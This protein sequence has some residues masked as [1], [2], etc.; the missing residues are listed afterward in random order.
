MLVDRYS[1]RLGTLDSVM[2]ITGSLTKVANGNAITMHSVSEVKQ[3]FKEKYGVTPTDEQCI[4]A[5]Y[6]NGNG[7]ASN[8]HFDGATLQG[9]NFYCTLSAS[10]TVNCRI[11]YMY[12]YDIS[13]GILEK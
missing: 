10:E 12:V 7:N 8:K 1:N 4:I 9:E 5:H 11:S 6:M 3:M 13:K 2:I